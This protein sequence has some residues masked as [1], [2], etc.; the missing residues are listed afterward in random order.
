MRRRF[1]LSIALILLLSLTQLRAQQK[2]LT[3]DD[4]FDP[5]TRVDFNGSPPLD[6]TWLKDGEHYLQRKFNRETRTS[7]LLKVKALTGESAPFYDATKMEAALRKLPGFSAEEAK[8]LATQGAYRMNEDRTAVLINHA[9]DLFY[10]P[11][12]S[13]T[14]V[15]L[16]NS[17]EPEVG[18][19]FSPD[20]KLVSFVRNYNLYVVDVATQ[21]ERA[22]T[23]DGGPERLNG[24][25]DWVYQEE[26]Y[27]R[28]DFKGYW[29]SPDSTK[30]AYLQ[31]D[32]SPVKEFTVVDH[33]PYRLELEVTNYPKAGDPNPVA[34]LGV[35]NAAGGQTR[36]VD[37]FKYQSIEF[38]IVRVGW[39]PDSKKVVYQVQ[40]REQTWLD[41]NFATPNDG[42]SETVLRET[43]KA[44]VNVTGQPHWLKD[45]SFLWLSER[46]G[47]QHLYHYA[48]DGK[49][50]RQVTSGPWEVRTLYGVDE[51]QGVVYFSA[52]EHSHIAP[53]TYRI[54][55]DG[56]G[57]DR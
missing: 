9:N 11:F 24:R 53:Q 46:T 20:A 8:R 33:I 49:L 15:R 22:L 36:W 7:Q 28:G 31:L 42:T 12:G 30:I 16:T 19:E 51:T 57:L 32:E 2:L 3:L 10:Y 45:G 55:L 4:L 56:T 38:L 18:E 5:K 47:W 40:D 21:R 26:V 44:W 52:T 37:T 48:A 23:T 41:L 39:T 25:L 29:W 6:L 27:G 35:V 14:A 43:S 13:D 50:I 54:K 1:A 34:R 17:P